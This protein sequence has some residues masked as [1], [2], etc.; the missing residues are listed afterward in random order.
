MTF[1][2]ILLGGLVTFLSIGFSHNESNHSFA[3]VFQRNEENAPATNYDEFNDE[4]ILPSSD[5]NSTDPML[6][7]LPA[8]LTGIPEP[9]HRITK[10]SFVRFLGFPLC[11]RK[12]V[13]KCT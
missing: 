3:R 4:D 11:L 7:A 12:R 9:C 2:R 10:K 8:R 6:I 5:I 1:L 13:K